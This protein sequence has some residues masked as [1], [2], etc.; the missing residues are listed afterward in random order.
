MKV[1]RFTSA[2]TLG[3][4][5]TKINDTINKKRHFLLLHTLAHWIFSTFFALLILKKMVLKSPIAALLN[6]D[7]ETFEI[8]GK[9]F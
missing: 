9:F 3:W 1:S 7:A 8:W 4:S 2:S 6:T 5:L